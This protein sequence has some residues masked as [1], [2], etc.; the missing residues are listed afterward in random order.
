MMPR[1]CSVVVTARSTTCRHNPRL[2]PEARP[3]LNRNAKGGP[4]GIFLREEGE[5][6][7]CLLLPSTD[8]TGNLLWPNRTTSVTT[9]LV[10]SGHVSYLPNRKLTAYCTAK[11]HN[12]G[13]LTACLRVPQRIIYPK[14]QNTA[15]IKIKFLS[16]FFWNSPALAWN[17][18][19][20]AS[21][22]QSEA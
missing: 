20:R 22:G 9:R 1:V 12:G 5:P 10:G 21:P 17:A 16:V 11:L 6:N 2:R 14:P 15:R 7:K 4:F 18:S 8:A 3:I 19:D 13:S